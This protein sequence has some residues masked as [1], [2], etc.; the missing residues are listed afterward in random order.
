V[1][2]Q[3]RGARAQALVAAHLAQHLDGVGV[4]LDRRVDHV[5][6]HRSVRCERLDEPRQVVFG[7]EAGVQETELR[8]HAHGGECDRS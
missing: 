3:R 1:L 2:A 8:G 6:D 7:G 4:L 5:G